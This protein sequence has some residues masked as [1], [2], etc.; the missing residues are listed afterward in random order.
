ML[1][2]TED[3]A[4]SCSVRVK[5]TCTGSGLTGG[6][7]PEDAAPGDV[8]RPSAEQIHN[9]RTYNPNFCKFCQFSN[10]VSVNIIHP[11]KIDSTELH[12]MKSHSHQTFFQE[13]I[14]H[15]HR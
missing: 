12:G 14:R 6:V 7:D 4:I 2:G 5:S 11:Q 8:V 13:N 10:S 3:K 1:P 15:D 9:M